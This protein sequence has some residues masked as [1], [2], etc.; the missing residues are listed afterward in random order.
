MSQPPL[1]PPFPL[2]RVEELLKENSQAQGWIHHNF[3]DS[4]EEKEV[5]DRKNQEQ[6]L[7]WGEAVAQCP[8]ACPAVGG[9][10]TGGRYWERATVK[11]REKEER[12]KTKQ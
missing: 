12:R 1:P 5:A 9:R 7:R 6:A 11:G 2:N 3:N 10:P 4:R 8:S